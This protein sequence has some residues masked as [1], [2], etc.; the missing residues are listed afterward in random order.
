MRWSASSS[1]RSSVKQSE[2]EAG[3]WDGSLHHVGLQALDH[4][5]VP[6][7]L[8]LTVHPVSHGADSEAG[9]RGMG[10]SLWSALQVRSWI[11]HLL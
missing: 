5:L 6:P 11:S 1:Q 9:S 3:G 10:Q 7:A 4:L 2:A 8:A